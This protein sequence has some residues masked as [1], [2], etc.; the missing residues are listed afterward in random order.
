MITR[1]RVEVMR[2]L[3]YDRFIASGSDWGTSVSTCVALQEPRASPR[4]TL[5]RP[6]LP[7]VSA[8]DTALTSPERAAL[9][10]LEQRSG[11]ASAYSAVSR[12]ASSRWFAVAS[13][14]Q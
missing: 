11:N 1:A 4:P 5:S 10:A 6:M 12:R 7:A 9:A 13:R 8:D 3:G 2:R 14:A